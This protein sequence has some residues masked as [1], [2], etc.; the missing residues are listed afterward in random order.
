MK[1]IK[2]FS[3]SDETA[4]MV[5]K[6]ASEKGRKQSDVVDSILKKFFLSLD[7]NI[8]KTT[9]PDIL[10]CKN[11]GSKYSRLLPHCPKCHPDNDVIKEIV[12]VNE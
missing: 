2:S 4:V 8:E 5:S 11:C 1:V 6:F 10:V 7:N 3:L 9:E 12:E